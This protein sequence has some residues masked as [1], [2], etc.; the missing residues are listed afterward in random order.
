MVGEPVA[1]F[2]GVVKLDCDV[3]V[4][5]ED[6]LHGGCE[7]LLIFFTKTAL[8]SRKG[9]HDDILINASLVGR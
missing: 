9:I 1:A 2:G 6:F 5:L 3:V 7:L 4:L 8:V